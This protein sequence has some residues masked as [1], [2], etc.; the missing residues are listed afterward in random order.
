MKSFKQFIGEGVYGDSKNTVAAKEWI[1]ALRKVSSSV[2]QNAKKFI[3]GEKT[4]YGFATAINIIYCKQDGFSKQQYDS[5]VQPYLKSKAGLTKLQGW[6]D[7]Y[8]F[9]DG[10]GK[11]SLLQVGYH[12]GGQWSEECFDFIILQPN[13]MMVAQTLG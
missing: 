8:C 4:S 5:V 9:D 7:Q 3:D 12:K 11:Y 6:K 10:N 1:T 2:A 13:K